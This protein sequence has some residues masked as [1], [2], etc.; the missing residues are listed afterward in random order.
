[1]EY[2]VQTEGIICSI[3]NILII[4]LRQSGIQ[5]VWSNGKCQ[6]NPYCITETVLLLVSSHQIIC[7]SVLIRPHVR[8]IFRNCILDILAS[9]ISKHCSRLP[10]D[11]ITQQTASLSRNLSGNQII[12]NFVKTLITQVSHTAIQT[13]AGIMSPV[14]HRQCLIY[15]NGCHFVTVYNGLLRARDRC[16][17]DRDK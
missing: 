10:T 3:F 12:N 14:N 5:V 2:P 16:H 6:I 7:C 9:G 11:V 1:M 13:H 8:S 4:P 17:T 15:D